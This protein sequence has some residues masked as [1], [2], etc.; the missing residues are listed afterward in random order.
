M[1][2]IDVDAVGRR[3]VVDIDFEITTTTATSTAST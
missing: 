3:P 2:S 1:V